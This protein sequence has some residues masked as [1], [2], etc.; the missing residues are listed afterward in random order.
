MAFRFAKGISKSAT[1]AL[2]FQSANV[3]PNVV[4]EF[5]ILLILQVLDFPM[6]WIS[7]V[8]LD[9]LLEQVYELSHNPAGE[10]CPH[11]HEYCPLGCDSAQR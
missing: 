8:I 5:N 1:F 2:L 11:K 7:L 4:D 9:T 6:N 10:G 3:S